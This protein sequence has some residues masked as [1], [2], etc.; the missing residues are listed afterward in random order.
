MFPKYFIQISGF[1][2]S[3]TVSQLKNVQLITKYTKNGMYRNAP[4]HRGKAGLHKI[5]PLSGPESSL[6]QHAWN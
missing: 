1:I 5:S 2:C 4:T 3:E 6:K